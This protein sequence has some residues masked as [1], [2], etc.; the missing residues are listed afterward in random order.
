MIIFLIKVMM[1]PQQKT[2][3]GF[4]YQIGINHLGH[5]RLTMLLLPIMKKT[6]GE[7]RIV[8]LSSSAHKM[9]SLKINFDDFQSEKSYSRI[10]SYAQSKLANILFA[11]EL[12]RKLKKDS[13]IVNS[14]HPGVIPSTDLT[15]DLP[16]LIRIPGL[17][18]SPILNLGMK[19]IEQGAATTVFATVS[20][21]L[22]NNGGNYLLNSHISKAIDYVYDESNGKKLWE[23]TEKLTGVV[24]PRNE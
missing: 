14:V 13:I 21:E 6:K 16:F 18:F 19:T 5:F 17:W 15:R 3:D 24:F 23:L 9:G 2:K 8:V 11:I 7:R 4:E 10:G 22:N 20:E 12:N 1:T